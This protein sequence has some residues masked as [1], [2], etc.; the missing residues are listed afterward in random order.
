MVADYRPEQEAVIVVPREHGGN[1]TYRMAGPIA[2]PEAYRRRERGR[3][4]PPTV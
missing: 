1:S 3:R 4:M 2:P